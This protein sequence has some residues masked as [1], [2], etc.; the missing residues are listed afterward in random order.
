MRATDEGSMSALTANDHQIEPRDSRTRN[1]GEWTSDPSSPEA[2]GEFG[3]AESRTVR[4][5]Q[6]ERSRAADRFGWKSRR[7]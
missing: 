6:A 7:H 3:H 5:V 2:A 4:T 1:E